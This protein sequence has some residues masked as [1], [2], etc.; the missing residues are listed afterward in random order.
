MVGRIWNMRLLHEQYYRQWT[1]R[2]TRMEYA[3]RKLGDSINNFKE[4][5]WK[6]RSVRIT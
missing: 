5:E 4:E 3:R 2:Y 1:L 6:I